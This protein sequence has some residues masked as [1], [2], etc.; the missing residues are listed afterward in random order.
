MQRVLRHRESQ[1]YFRHGA[2]T[3]NPAD[4]ESFEDVEQAAEACLRY[5]LTDV[6]E[7]LRYHTGSCDVFCT[8]L[9]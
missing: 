7:V 6:E 3:R 2:W 5:G 8:P 9:R 4:A 1:A